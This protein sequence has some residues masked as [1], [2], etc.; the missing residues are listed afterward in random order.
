MTTKI[1]YEEGD[2]HGTYTN[3]IF[4]QV[5]KHTDRSK[6]IKDVVIEWTVRIENKVE[7]HGKSFLEFNGYERGNAREQRAGI[8]KFDQLTT[9]YPRASK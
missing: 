3:S 9:L 2:K 5:R 6:R 8:T 1:L 7:C 4:V